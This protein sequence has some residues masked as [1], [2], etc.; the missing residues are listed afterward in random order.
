LGELQLQL[1]AIT[2]SCI[3]TLKKLGMK[4]TPQRRL[5]LDIVHDAGGHLTA[6]E[7]L[8]YVQARAPGVNKST[9]YRTLELLEELGCVVKSESGDVSIYHHTE[10][11]H[12]HHLVCQVCGKSIDCDEDLF[13]SVERAIDERYGF[14]VDFR[15]AVV[16]GLCKECGSKKGQ[17]THVLHTDNSIS[18]N[19]PHKVNHNHVDN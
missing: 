15:H 9:V 13:S 1:G 4:L 8:D 12:H 3:N 19:R 17:G 6:E 11:G 18:R 10:E 14:R 2:M 16:S 5:I 7:I